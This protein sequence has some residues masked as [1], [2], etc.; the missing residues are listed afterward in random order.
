MNPHY[1]EVHN[2][3]EK[4]QRHH[5]CWVASL[6]RGRR[7][8]NPGWLRNKGLGTFCYAKKIQEGLVRFGCNLGRIIVYLHPKSTSSSCVFWHFIYVTN[9]VTNSVTNLVITK[10]SSC[11]CLCLT[12]FV[13]VTPGNSAM[14]VL[15][16]RA[17][18]K[19]STCMVYSEFWISGENPPL[20]G[21]GGG[22][23]L[24]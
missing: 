3:L 12:V 18:Q 1:V 10:K 17:F 13:C 15:V 2:K 5:Y 21:G 20:E 11:I 19:C 23:N 8:T 6:Q 4:D 7:V 16:P 24:L 22:K 14:G 9:L